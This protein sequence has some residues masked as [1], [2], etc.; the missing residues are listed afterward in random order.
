MNPDSP[1]ELKVKRVGKRKR[2]QTPEECLEMVE[3]MNAEVVLLSP[4]KR[5]RGFV[6]RFKTYADYEAWKKAQTNPWLW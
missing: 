6:A 2:P 4:F 3:R 5:P 1:Y